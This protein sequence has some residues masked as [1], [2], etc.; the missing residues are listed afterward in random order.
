MSDFT[1]YKI[2]IKDFIKCIISGKYQLPCF[3][4]DFKWN[5]SK[6]K[7]LINSIQHEY[8]AGSLL[9]LKIDGDNP[10]IPYQG[11][12]FTDKET[13]TEK[14]EKLVLDGQQRM[15]SCFSVFKNLGNYTYYINYSELMN[16]FNSGIT[17]YDF[18]T[19]IIHKKHVFNPSKEIPNGL[20]PMEYLVDRDTMIAQIKLFVQDA[21]RDA[22]NEK[23]CDFLNYDFVR[24][25]DSILDY[26]FPVVDLP[27]NSSMESVC[28]V[29]QTINT[30]GL[31]LSVFDICLAV[32]MPKN[33]NLKKL[34]V[35]SSASTN[36][37]K[38]VLCKDP[39]SALQV[40]AL[41]A[42]RSP[43]AN[44]LPKELQ[45]QDITDFWDD[46][47]EGIES[48]LILFD[49]FGAGTK[50]NLSILPYTP[51]VTIVAAVLSRTKYKFMD[52]PTKGEAEEKIKKYFFTA[53]LTSRYTEGTNAKINEDFKSLNQW[54]SNDIIPAMISHGVDWNTEIIISNKK[55]SAFGKA[56]LCMLNARNPKDFYRSKY[57][58]VREN[59]ESCDLHHIFPKAT[60]EANNES[61]INSVFNLTWLTKD[62]N[63][64]IKDNTTKVY[65]GNIMSSLGKTEAQLKTD[66]EL[67]NIDDETY[68]MLINENYYGFI[69]KRANKYRN[70]F[71]EV[72]VN[73][74][75][76]DKD[77]VEVEEN[78]D[79]EEIV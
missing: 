49:S 8:P 32:F 77:E 6:I 13:F 27:E 34:V 71:S 23:L 48:A 35:K 46:A 15:T 10:L 37:A 19:L 76:V 28:K 3:Q 50:K 25:V 21:R 54:V 73:F 40:V 4:R 67:H 38:N 18:E 61:L 36:Y 31:K 79:E 75:D 9:F 22:K 59:V 33:I 78:E 2:K 69:S 24:I 26:E 74:R 16:Q 45:S 14:P 52:V 58:G 30:T 12:K 68:N 44:S 62:S 72:G 41:L 7:S 66:L 17:D 57:V 29:F 63:N 64:Y 60:Y 51:L 20:F 70:L 56:V 1:P 39:T 47:I 5:P 55:N 11:F 53:S 43:N 42:N 65:L